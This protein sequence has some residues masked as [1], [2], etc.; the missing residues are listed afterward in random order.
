MSANACSETTEKEDGPCLSHR[1]T[2]LTN[3]STSN[4]SS[5]F[6]DSELKASNS[7]EL[8]DGERDEEEDG[9]ND[10]DEW[11]VLNEIHFFGDLL[12]VSKSKW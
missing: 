10:G 11:K 1:S 3:D 5:T 12:R 4:D 2:D 7:S 9:V 8:S 6:Q